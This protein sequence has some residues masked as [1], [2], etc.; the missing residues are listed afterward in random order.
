[1]KISS[2]WTLALMLVIVS[3]TLS[4]A[5]EYRDK[6]IVISKTFRNSDP[7]IQYIARRDLEVLVSDATAPGMA[8][9]A[10]K[11][12]D[13]LLY[14]L[15]QKDV[16][17]EAKKYILRQLARVGTSKAVGPL[18]QIMLGKDKRLAEDARAAI[19][20]I[21][22]SKASNALKAAYGKMD[23]EGKL[24]ILKSLALRGES[25]SVRFIANEL[26]NGSESISV[27]AAWA[28]GEIENSG[29][30]RA[31]R[32]AYS[33]GHSGSVKQAIERSLL[34]NPSVGSN[35][36]HEIF[37][38]GSDAASRRAALRTLIKR[39]DRDVEEAIAQGLQS[40]E[41]DLRT[42]AIE[43]S[44]S[45]GVEKFQRAVLDRVVEMG[46]EDMLTVLG[47][48]NNVEDEVAES[49]A[50]QVIENGDESLRLNALDLIGDVGSERSIDLLLNTFENGDRA[51]QIKAASAIAQIDAPELD[52]RLAGMLKS[53]DSK[54][55]LFAQEVLVYRNI[56]N[57]KMY[58]VEAVKSGDPTIARG[59]LKTLSVIADSSDLDQLYAIAN[60]KSGESKRLIVS[61]LK[62]LAPEFGSAA[63]QEHVANL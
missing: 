36:L 63:L 31:L 1:M 41:A 45:S 29:S 2:N 54:K 19:E 44:L 51:S 15:A 52:E 46:P 60:S 33:V 37:S 28:L 9:G 26:E 6:V 7:D 12:T 40:E 5:G 3:S 20:S 34:S 57:A 25:S 14:A 8:N 43:S 10:S 38:E 21:R 59:A 56:P 35:L 30:L 50:L 48:L 27:T 53:S 47:G 24:N 4:L 18:S 42:I 13:D 39:Q 62:K 16:P 17:V 22:G 23:T 55:V 11:I 32:N 61:L 58:L 49:I